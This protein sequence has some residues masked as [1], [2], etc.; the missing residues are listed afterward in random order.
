MKKLTALILAAMMIFA[1]CAAL[2][3]TVEYEIPEVGKLAG[4]TVHATVGAY[5]AED[6]T[7]EVTVYG[8]DT[9]TP[10]A[11]ANA[12]V[13]DT[14]LAGGVLHQIRGT[15]MAGDTLYYDCDGEQFCFDRLED[16][17]VIARSADD[18]RIFMHVIAVLRL[19]AA[20]GIILE[21]NSDPDLDAQMKVIEGLD[22]I[23]KVQAEKEA[24]SIGFDF[25]ATTVT[26]NEAL[27]IVK[28]H[29]DFDVAQ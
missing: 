5:H 27:E 20:A 9:F 19:P 8:Y 22:E 21:D 15:E 29:Q 16:G 26:L 11:A 1:A 28:I 25:Y 14:V 17:T 3:G 24:Y 13:G 10:E 18:D 23:L 2:A 7:F 6:N 12:T 4:S